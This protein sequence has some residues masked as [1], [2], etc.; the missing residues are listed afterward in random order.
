MS[1]VN[2]KIKFRR[3]NNAVFDESGNLLLYSSLLGIK[4]V[5]LATRKVSRLLGAREHLRSINL[6]LF[7]GRVKSLSCTANT[8]E[9]EA[10]ENP[11]LTNLGTDPTLVVTAFK[12]NRFYLFSDRS[13]KDLSS[14][15]N[16][17]DVFNEKPSKED[18][19]SA[20]ETERGAPRL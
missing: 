2:S 6:G 10:S 20:T 11:G 17:R 1:S 3:Y 16:D 19:I 5:N 15:D 9:M 14:V 12:K 18:I 13:S 7:Q 4:M 8:Q